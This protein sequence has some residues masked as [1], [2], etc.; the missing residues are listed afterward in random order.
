[1]RGRE[2][3]KVQSG[4]GRGEQGTKGPD[5][6]A[7]GENTQGPG[8]TVGDPKGVGLD[9]YTSGMRGPEKP[10]QKSVDQAMQ[11]TGDN[12]AAGNLSGN[13]KQ[14]PNSVVGK[15]EGENPE[16]AG[17]RTGVGDNQLQSSTTGAYKIGIPGNNTEAAAAG[18]EP[19][20]EEDDTHINVRIPK[21]SLKRKASGVQGQ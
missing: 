8:K 16:V 9:A 4:N 18:M 6:G 7:G 1:M 3:P 12:V 21:A 14:G 20:A 13:R 19:S 2:K 5:G 15:P 11:T 17:K 10:K